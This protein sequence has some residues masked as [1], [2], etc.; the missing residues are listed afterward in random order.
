MNECWFLGTID[1]ILPAQQK[2]VRGDVPWTDQALISHEDTIKL[3]EPLMCAG[4]HV[5][6]DGG[7]SMVPKGYLGPPLIRLCSICGLKKLILSG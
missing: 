6:Q 4:H 2:L 7:L 3:V 5:G 1:C